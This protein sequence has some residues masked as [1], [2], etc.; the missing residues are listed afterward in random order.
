MEAC[1]TMSAI[2]LGLALHHIPTHDV[3]D[4]CNLNI[5]AM[6]EVC[7]WKINLILKSKPN[8]YNHSFHVQ[9]CKCITE[10][11]T[12]NFLYTQG[13]VDEK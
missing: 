1:Q 11:F 4:K 5:Y 13:W 2:V 6:Y 9:Y 7:G 3:L 10:Y 12:N 8:L